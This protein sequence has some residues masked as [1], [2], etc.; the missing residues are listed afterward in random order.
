MITV[1]KINVNPIILSNVFIFQG[2]PQV[3]FIAIF[4]L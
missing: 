3:T 4:S 2:C 1:K